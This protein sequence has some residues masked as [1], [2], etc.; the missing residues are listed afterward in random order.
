MAEIHQIFALF[1]FGKLKTQ[2]SH[3][4]VKLPLDAV[5]LRKLYF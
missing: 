5:W 2:K 4:E 3:S 1:F